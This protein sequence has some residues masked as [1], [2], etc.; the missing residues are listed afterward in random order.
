MK[1][2]GLVLFDLLLNFIVNSNFL[3]VNDFFYS[4]AVLFL[5]GNLSCNCNFVEVLSLS[6]SHGDKSLSNLADLFCLSFCCNDLA[7]ADQ[8][9]YLV[10]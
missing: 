8:R 6:Y 9:S 2:A 10:S 1:S 5:A 4:L 3:T 7:V